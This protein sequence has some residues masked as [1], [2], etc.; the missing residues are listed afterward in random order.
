MTPLSAEALAGGGQDLPPAPYGVV[1]IVAAQEFQ[2]VFSATK[3]TDGKAVWFDWAKTERRV[4]CYY[5]YL[6]DREFGPG[7]IKIC[8]YFP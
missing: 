1:A 5:F 2:W 3:K 6:H 8:T 7:F 4:S